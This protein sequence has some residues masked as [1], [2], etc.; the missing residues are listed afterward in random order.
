MADRTPRLLLPFIAAAQA[1]KH[2]THNEALMDLDAIVQLGVTARQSTPPASPAP[3][4]RYIVGTSPS[5]AFAGKTH[6]VAVYDD[7]VWRFLTPKAG[8]M[9]W[10]VQEAAIFVFNGTSWIDARF[11]NSPMIGVNA[12][13]DT[14]N[15]LT[16]SSPA[17]LF[18]HAGAGMQAKLNKA[19]ASDTASLLFQTGFS[20]R[21]EMGTAG[22]DAFQIKVSADGSAWR[23]GL[24]I[25]PANGNVGIGA[26][27]GAGFKLDVAGAARISG[28]T[29]GR[30][31]YSQPVSGGSWGG[32]GLADSSG[33][34]RWLM[35][36]NP[37]NFW[38]EFNRY[39]AN[40][41]YQDTP[42]TIDPNTG[43][44]GV[45][46]YGPAARLHVGGF[47]GTGLLIEGGGGAVQGMATRNNFV[48]ASQYGQTR[49]ESRNEAGASVATMRSDFG[50]DGSTA[51][52]WEAQPTGARTDRRVERFLIGGNGEVRPG[53]DNAQSLGVA[54]IRWSSI[55]S[56]NGTIQTS[57]IRLKNVDRPIA[58]D[59]AAA[60]VAA[61]E[62]ILFRWKVGGNTV[63]TV[64]DGVE[65]VEEQAS[66][67]VEI[68]RERI[69]MR[70]GRAVRFVETV[71][72]RRPLF[73]EVP[74]FDEAGAPVMRH[75]VGPDGAARAVPLTHAVP[76]MIRTERAKTRT[77]TIAKPGQRIHAGFSAQAMRAALEAQGLDCGA[78]GLADK[79]D[80]DSE[81]FLRPDQLIPILWAAVKNLQTRV[82]ALE[83]GRRR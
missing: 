67:P 42:V 31:F 14:T 3:G 55:W 1:Q 47:N 61:V 26:A 6:L 62:P 22:S 76:R 5:G 71:T 45:G 13:A 50:T 51:W 17:V 69:E 78:W 54:G 27:P 20:G 75:E 56:V 4:D 66:E 29:I 53:V 15:R 34:T 81:Q 37:S 79:A 16:V 80:P 23:V 43:F 44:F 63:E 28:D 60:V 39:A 35:V 11:V 64:E 30:T 38:L 25:D 70:D 49:Y 57:D 36:R 7:A 65:I 77:Q 52:V 72:E 74:V 40:G 48:S 10:I 21:A 46:S 33:I 68:A 9:A 58:P 18:N 2:V 83:A 59:D 32:Y 41:A 12:T 8:W 19:A 82:R 73:D 24:A